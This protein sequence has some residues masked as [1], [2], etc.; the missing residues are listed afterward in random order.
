[1]AELN[2]TRL[3][4]SWILT[5][6]SKIPGFLP[7][8]QCGKPSK[9]LVIITKMNLKTRNQYRH[10]LKSRQNLPT[11]SHLRMQKQAKKL[12]KNNKRRSRHKKMQLTSE[13]K[14]TNIIVLQPINEI[15]HFLTQQHVNSHTHVQPCINHHTPKHKNTIFHIIPTITQIPMF[16]FLSLHTSPHLRT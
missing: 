16:E 3:P 4:I 12:K 5:R 1:M 15:L 7:A 14:P 9:Q 10:K 13:S 11:P 2:D 8:L 6:R